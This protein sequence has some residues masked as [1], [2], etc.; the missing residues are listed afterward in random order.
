VTGR[1]TD[2]DV[3]GGLGNNA[4]D[5][6]WRFEPADA[7]LF[8]GRHA[9]D[10]VVGFPGSRAQDPAAVGPDELEG[11][12]AFAIVYGGSRAAESSKVSVMLTGSE[13]RDTVGLKDKGARVALFLRPEGKGPPEGSAKV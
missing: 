12:V 9:A 13:V 10:T 11:V 3:G 2:G 6:G 7:P 8:D 4:D 1:R 5:T